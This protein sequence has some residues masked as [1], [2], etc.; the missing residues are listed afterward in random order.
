MV[1]THSD[2][3]IWNDNQLTPENYRFG[4]H[5]SNIHLAS[6]FS[7]GYKLSG[8]LSAAVELAHVE[9]DMR[10]RV[11]AHQHA[12]MVIA[13]LFEQNTETRDVQLYGAKLS[14]IERIRSTP[15]AH[16]TAH[17]KDTR[18]KPEQAPALME[19]T[20]TYENSEKSVNIDSNIAHS[21]LNTEKR[22]I[23]LRTLYPDLLKDEIR[24]KL[25]I[26]SLNETPTYTALSYC[27][28]KIMSREE[29]LSMRIRPI[30][31]PFL[32][33]LAP[34]ILLI[35]RSVLTPFRTCLLSAGP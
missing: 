12:S 35:D 33:F 26:F 19:L 6:F 17:T 1:L 25:D 10:K 31:R 5:I 21:A 30:L 9:V 23:R 18:V 16:K 20:V 11:L 4:H 24:C 14:G 29:S 28:A 8:R 27:W 32:P 22:E 7:K 2:A 34:F 15:L 13:E 3:C